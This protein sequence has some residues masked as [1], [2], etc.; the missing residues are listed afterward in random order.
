[1]SGS[2]FAEASCSDITSCFLGVVGVL[3]Q[4][5]PQEICD[6]FQLAVRAVSNNLQKV[7]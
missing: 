6:A 5:N 7:R 3:E 4:G 1:M 2:E